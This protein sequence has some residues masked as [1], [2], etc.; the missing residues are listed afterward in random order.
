M[1]DSLKIL[2]TGG[3]HFTAENTTSDLRPMVREACGKVFRRTNRF[4]DLALIGANRCANGSSK[5]PLPACPVYTATGQCSLSDTVELMHQIQTKHQTPMPFTFINVSSNT[6]GFYIGQS[7]ALEGENMT[8]SRETFPFEAALELA[9]FGLMEGR[10]REA[11]VGG[12][13]ELTRPLDHHRRRLRLSKDAPIGEGSHWLHLGTDGEFVAEITRLARFTDESRFCET[14]TAWGMD[15]M[16]WLA[17]G[18]GV[19]EAMLERL[20]TR[21][22][23][24]RRFDYISSAGYYESNAA[25]GISRFIQEKPAAELLHVNRDSRGFLTALRLVTH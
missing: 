18:N 22:E 19:D 8:V 11:L 13:D 20:E 6:A 9:W 12:V 17:G 3:V 14:A 10:I 5:R 24:G 2:S 16:T 1:I 7:L 25:Q 21:L 15:K 23:T 4:I